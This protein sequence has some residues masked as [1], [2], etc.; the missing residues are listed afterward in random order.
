MTTVAVGK[1]TEPGAFLEI[2]GEWV[3]DLDECIAG[4]KG[5]LETGNPEQQRA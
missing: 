5:Q 3:D 4:G 1:S 2:V